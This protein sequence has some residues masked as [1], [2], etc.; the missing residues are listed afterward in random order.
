LSA[1]R[2]CCRRRLRLGSF[3]KPGLQWL[4]QLHVA[5]LEE[6]GAEVE[7]EC[8]ADQRQQRE[9]VLLSLHEMRVSN[10]KQAQREWSTNSS[11]WSACCGPRPESQ[12]SR[13]LKRSALL[14]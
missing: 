14:T 2:S 10:R 9:G 6:R 13:G 1:L 8:L 5:D 7:A 12:Q 3:G 11:R 4:G